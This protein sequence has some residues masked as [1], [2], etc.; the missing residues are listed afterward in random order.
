MRIYTLLARSLAWYWR[1][2][3][4]VLLGVATAT[5]VLGGAVLVGESVR[6]SLR[7]LVLE[8]L[9]NTDSIVTGAG[10]FREELA[11]TFQ[12]AAPIIVMDGV[13]EHAS[14]GKRAT[15]VQVYGIDERFRKFQN[16]S[17]DAPRGREIAL[18]TALARELG[19]TA[20]DELLLRVA[21]PSA[22]P[23][24]SLHGR[25]DDTGI[26]IRLTV[27]PAGGHSHEFS[28]R[29][30][31]GD[32][33]A[34][35]VPLARL[36]R[37]LNQP[38]KVNT[39]LV[40]RSSSA[41][42]LGQRLKHHYNLADVGLR[43]RTLEKP[44]CLSLESSSAEIGD[45]VAA[46]AYSAARSLGLS[47]QPV[48]TYLA[49]SIR[50]GKREIPFSVVTALD[51]PLAPAG[52]EGITL[53]DWAARDL[54]AKVGDPATLEYYVWRSDARLHT[55]TAQFRVERIVP[56]TGDADDADFAPD[57]PGITE[58]RSLR[59]WDPPF[60]LDMSR[61]RPADEQYWDRYRTAPKAFVRL[62]RG[63]A[64]WGTRFGS[65]TSIRIFPPSAAFDEALRTALDPALAGLA[66]IPVRAQS[67][68]AA[69]GS[70][71]FGEY[72]IYF[73]FFLMVSA[74]LLTGL[75]FRLGIEQRAREIG[76]LRALGFSVSKIRVMF[77]L[78]GAVLAA[79]GA[80]MGVGAALGYGAL[81]LLGLRSW[82]FD[83]VGTRLLSLHASV[84]SLAVGTAAGL[85]AGLGSVAW[86][87]RGMQPV[88]PRGLLAGERKSVRLR[89]RWMA[90]AAA[91]ALAAA[92]VGAALS[93]KLDQAAG[94][95]GAGTLLLIAALLFQSVWLHA[96]GLRT[97]GGL[98]ALGLRSVQY[99]PG[100]SVLSIALIASG[101]F[102]IA[103]LDS[104]RRD[105]SPAGAGGFALL[106]DAAL[107]LIH[108]P[109]TE[110]GR[111]ALNIPPLEGVR[112]VPF[113]VRPGDDASCLNLYQS[114]NPRIMAPRAAFLRS[115]R[116]AFQ[117]AA[118]R[119]AN[120]WLLLESPLEGGAVPAIADA[121]S[122]D[123][124]LHR[125]L[126]EEFE[127]GGVRYRVV[128]ALQDSVFQ[129]ELIISEANFLR[130]F[131]DAQGYR[132]FL[133]NTPPGKAAE[134]ARTLEA[135]LSDYGFDVQPTAAVLESFHRVE[136]TYLSTFRALGGLGLVLGTVGL[137]ALLMRN[138]LERRRELALLRA[139]GYRRRHLFEIVL[140][141]DAFLLLMGLA[142]GAVCAA[143]A[144]APAVAARGGHVPVASLGA[145][146]LLVA[147]TGIASSAIATAVALRSG[148]L[149]ALR[150]E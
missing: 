88:T 120:P 90:G 22:I 4:A 74:L 40:G 9:G 80:A 47:A 95:F 96:R 100:R 32:V 31:Q 53:N 137:A 11:R 7:D 117:G 87:L 150:S 82:W 17:V 55:E 14:S 125:K 93:G 102:V 112:F 39:I 148:L 81:I 10:F 146:L 126:G 57:Y 6:A 144:A 149:D 45:A 54:A 136:N 15:G 145:L 113:R 140:A 3:L 91:V 12:P 44:G 123:Y 69:Q 108:D 16:Q 48:L 21:K 59:D 107:P 118:G 56:L 46:A 8:R 143:L 128:A 84:P 28:L 111:A 105:A 119:S 41:V 27:A 116:F 76:V 60:P 114:R 18:S 5:G 131:P 132:F 101:T 79:A 141:E 122:L 130:L 67:L 43:L 121:N 134:V 138:V 127:L 65:L 68:E 103:S 36:Q 133:L 110:A 58:S 142:T 20:G 129:G 34:V 25:K 92:L 83:A 71:D 35:Y 62:A 50:V 19:A 98:F 29:P 49:N 33:R 37:D 106:A 2:N 139:V 99:R 78:E 42:P 64:L 104:F 85:I 13:V 124:A 1:T 97:I 70:T 26:A 52:E 89:W 94:F 135:A 115:A 86:T 73:S 72:F 30:Q 51:S 24:E 66:A 63:R 38:G 77:L 75:L 61:I 23:L 109:N 147:L